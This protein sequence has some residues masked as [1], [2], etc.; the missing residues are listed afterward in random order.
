MATFRY[1]PVGPNND[2]D[3][4]SLFSAVLT[5]TVDNEVMPDVNLSWTDLDTA[6]LTDVMA[7]YVYRRENYGQAW[8][9]LGS[10]AG[11]TYDDSSVVV[12]TLYYYQVKAVCRLPGGGTQEV[13]SN[14]VNATPFAQGLTEI[15]FAISEGGYFAKLALSVGTDNL[16]TTDYYYNATYVT[17]RNVSNIHFNIPQTH[18][19][20]TADAPN[21]TQRVID[22]SDMSYQNALHTGTVINGYAVRDV[23]TN[24][25][26]HT[27]NN[28]VPYKYDMLSDDS[29]ID[30][31]T[32]GPNASDL[33][34]G[35]QGVGMHAIDTDGNMWIFC[36]SGIVRTCDM[37]PSIGGSWTTVKDVGAHTYFG[38][39]GP[40]A[41]YADTHFMCACYNKN[42]GSSRGMFL[43]VGKMDGT[44]TP[45]EIDLNETPNTQNAE[46][47]PMRIRTKGNYAYVAC[48]S[49]Q[50]TDA[51][52]GT[53]YP[54][55]IID[56]TDPD[57]PTEET[58]PSISETGKQTPNSIVI[59]DTKLYLC[60][61]RLVDSGVKTYDARLAIFD[62]SDP[63]A[64]VLSRTLQTVPIEEAVSNTAKDRLVMASPSDESGGRNIEVTIT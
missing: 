60:Y 13:W 19:I 1:I 50:A 8:T 57:A 9:L 24:S 40:M 59:S 42:D 12:D 32:S 33:M 39:G 22:Y 17:N 34:G 46:H 18:A 61:S 35:G 16:T 38:G 62:I 20:I 37:Y 7:F 3:H 55:R 44:G 41:L 2:R 4:Q 63:T 51:G 49:G 47:E 6:Y 29:G 30:A 45:T 27:D 26:T 48:I 15:F 52:P 56:M 11:M 5:L 23:T 58:R 10:T 36:R 31:G 14:V 21:M 53:R 64:V 28:P 25:Y 43:Y 54:L